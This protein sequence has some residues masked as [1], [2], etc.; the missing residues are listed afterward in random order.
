MATT[1]GPATVGVSVHGAMLDK[2][3]VK[4]LVMSLEFHLK[5]LARA[6]KAATIPEAGAAMAREQVEV[7]RLLQSFRAASV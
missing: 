7:T 2:A 3:D 6:E 4:R 5:S 1:A